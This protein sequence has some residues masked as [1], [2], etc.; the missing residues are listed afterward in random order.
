MSSSVSVTSEPLVALRWI[1]VILV[2]AVAPFV[3]L[4][5]V[6]VL[7]YVVGA[8]A[9]IATR[10]LATLVERRAAASDNPKT[11][12][13]LMLFTG[14]GRAWLLGLSILVVGLA[15]SREG[16]AHRG[17]RGCRR[18]HAV[19]RPRHRNGSQAEEVVVTMSSRRKLLLGIGGFYLFS[20]IAVIVIF[21]AKRQDNPAFKPQNEF[22]LDTWVNLGIFSINKAVLYVFVAAILTVWTMIYI[23]KR[24]QERPN[25]VQTA[26][27]LLFTTD[28]RQHHA[29]QHGRRHGREV[30]PVPRRRCSSS[31]G[32][33]T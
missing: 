20:I 16:R 31:S 17:D 30:V 27:E 1:D 23:A 7:G 9:W 26:V 15:G 33:R 3:L 28:A 32:S 11:V 5:G 29:R 12:A 24:M 18:V 14:L 13:G 19:P 6:P 4:T 10:L 22:K 21:G 25:R 2:V 8:G